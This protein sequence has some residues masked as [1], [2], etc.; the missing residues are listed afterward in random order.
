MRRDMRTGSSARRLFVMVFWGN[1]IMF[2]LDAARKVRIISDARAMMPA[3]GA[4]QCYI[5]TTI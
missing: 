5:P 3:S 2:L 4:R 1:T